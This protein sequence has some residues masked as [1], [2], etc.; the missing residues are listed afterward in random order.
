[1]P[2]DSNEVQ[3]KIDEIST[4]ISKLELKIHELV[5]IKSQLKTIVDKTDIERNPDGSIKFNE[6]GEKINITI[7]PTDE[8]TGEELTDERRNSIKDALFA[9][10]AIISSS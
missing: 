2:F 6:F 8:Y 5:K 9:K 10:E 4:S 1:M 7:K 3:E